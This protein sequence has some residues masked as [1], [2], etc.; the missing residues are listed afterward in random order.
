MAKPEFFELPDG[1]T[2]RILFE[3]RSVLAIDKPAGWM[4]G[5]DDAEHNERNLHRAL[6]ESIE[7]GE[8]WAKSRNVKFVRFV[9]RLD[10]PTTGILLLSKSQGAMRPL[11]EL[12][13][14]RR[15]EKRYL[16]VTDGVPERDQWICR[17][18]LGPD[19]DRPGRHRVDRR[20][21][22]PAETEFRV[23]AKTAAHALVEALPYS[24][25]THQIRLH[26][27]AAKCPVS[28]DVLY[29]TPDS[30]GLA[31]R[32]VGMNYPDPFTRKPVRIR[33]DEG[34]FCRR[35]GFGAPEGT[36][37]SP[38]VSRAVG[39][40]S[41]RPSGRSAVRRRSSGGTEPTS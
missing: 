39:E 14:T 20:E 41:D 29:G 12:F 36:V 1:A 8:W 35:Y 37:S 23:L 34:E 27:L 32:A 9:H 19:P 38:P 40:G 10:A 5:P 22:K 26:L 17:E 2:V 6:V 25:R 3:N 24:G 21:G 30:R 7:A 33:A 15:V 16:A 18:P 13:A 28:G 4:L 11:S 31:L